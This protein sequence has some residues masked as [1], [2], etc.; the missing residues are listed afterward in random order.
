MLILGYLAAFVSLMGIIL[1][2]R[3]IMACWPIWLLSN[4]MWITYSGIEGDVPSIILWT[5]FSIFNVYGWWKWRQ[6]KK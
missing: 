1:N 2:A 5:T 6:D 4:V 3:K